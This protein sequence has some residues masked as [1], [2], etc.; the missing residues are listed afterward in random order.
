MSGDYTGAAMEDEALFAAAVGPNQ[1]YYLPRFRRFARGGWLSWNW[2]AFFATFA[3][4]HHRKLHAWAALY[5]LASMP[6]LVW[7]LPT[8][9]PESCIGESTTD[10]RAVAVAAIAGVVLIV[11]PLVAD[12]LYFAHVRRL[13]SRNAA[14]DVSRKGGIDGLVAPVV[15]QAV[16]L[17]LGLAELPDMGY[18]MLRAKISEGVAT[19]AAAAADVQHYQGAHGGE[20]PAGIEDATKVLSS[21]YVDRIDMAKDG[22]L[23]ATFNKLAGIAAGH[24]VS[25]AAS[26]KSGD[27]TQYRCV[28]DDIAERC[29]PKQCKGR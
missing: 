2:A 12:R 8:A 16:V 5:V 7:W 1:D 19:V 27:A 21:T 17:A 23:R 4:L 24:S 13:V 26:G 11:P 20:L 18:Y 14:G 28:S 15:V 29:L 3:W 22:T 10:W 9:H 25:M 6:F